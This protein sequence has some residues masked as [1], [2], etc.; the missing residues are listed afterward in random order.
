MDLNKLL[1]DKTKFSLMAGPC[2]IESEEHF[3]KTATYVKEAGAQILRGGIYKLR[4]SKD[5]FQGLGLEGYELAN[6][7]RK[8]MDMPF[9]TEITDPRQTSALAE[10]TDIFQVGSRNMYN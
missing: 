5:S 9:V 1:F 7:V 10:V 2:S 8:N 4:T 6:K 3:Q